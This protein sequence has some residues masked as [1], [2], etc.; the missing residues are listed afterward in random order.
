[1]SD[2][3]KWERLLPRVFHAYHWQPLSV[4]KVRGAF[5]VQT[6]SNT[7]ALKPIGATEERLSFLHKMTVHLLDKNY[8]H[9][10]PW[11]QTRR[12][13]PF[14]L[15][16]GQAFYATPWYGKEFSSES[17]PAIGELARSLG[18]MHQLTKD[19]TVS[20]SSS[21][22]SLTQTASRVNAQSEQLRA[23]AE[24][25]EQRTNKSPFDVTFLENVEEL[26]QGATFAVKGIQRAAVLAAEKPFRQ[27]Y[28]HR[29]IHRHNVVKRGGRWKWIDFD[30]ADLDVP[31][32]DLAVLLQRFVSEDTSLQTLEGV[33][34]AYE[35]AL[36]IDAREKRL[37]GLLLAYPDHV[38]R[39]LR[40][41]Y[42]RDGQ[43][44]EMASVEQ[45]KASIARY[46]VVKRLAKQ[47]VTRR[48]GSARR[49]K[50]SVK[51]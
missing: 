19:V 15:H 21:T 22:A 32:R 3:Q 18:E 45:L 17:S 13:D 28:C 26:Q 1:M 47:L 33:L 8:K 23:Y 30:K 5:R 42:D 36:K 20:S 25:A 51:N 35:Q 31:V 2:Q 7:F 49:Q 40:R 50:M 16:E 43:R 10:L 9:V 41:Y 34:L 44:E 6:S 39:Q 48:N 12:G 24:T 11:M 37:L 27:V 46:Q 29:S 4:R 14:F 38:F